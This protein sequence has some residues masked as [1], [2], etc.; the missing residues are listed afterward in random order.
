MAKCADSNCG[1]FWQD[2]DENY[3]RCHYPDNDPFPAP[4][5]YEEEEEETE[6][7]TPVYPCDLHGVCPHC[8]Q[9]CSVC[10][11]IGFV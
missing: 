7:F 5:E 2:P 1:Y 10:S 6:E 9:N 11:P 8:E 4:C 3:P